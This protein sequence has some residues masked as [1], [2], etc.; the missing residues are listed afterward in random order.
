[1]WLRVTLRVS[2]NFLHIQV[3]HRSDSFLTQT[4]GLQGRRIYEEEKTTSE[5]NVSC[6]RKRLVVLVTRIETADYKY[7]P[8]ESRILVIKNQKF[9][10]SFLIARMWRS[11]F[12]QTTSRP[13][14]Q[15]LMESKITEMKD[16]IYSILS[17][18]SNT[19]RS[20]RSSPFWLRSGSD[21]S[22]SNAASPLRISMTI[23]TGLILHAISQYH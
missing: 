5:K 11:F 20:S 18:T 23:H 2:C 9:H 13:L 3:I 15:L 14:L 17:F 8:L 22:G 21:I 12:N 7:Y 19:Q 6:K 10:D 16:F 1:M 4:N